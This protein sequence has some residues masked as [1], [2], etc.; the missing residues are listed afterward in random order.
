MTLLRIVQRSIYILEVLLVISVCIVQTAPSILSYAKVTTQR[1]RDFGIRHGIL[2]CQIG[3]LIHPGI[4]KG[5]ITL[6][7]NGEYTT[8]I[9]HVLVTDGHQINDQVLLTVF[10]IDGTPG[11]LSYIVNTTFHFG[12]YI[13]PTLTIKS[14]NAGDRSIVNY[15]ILGNYYSL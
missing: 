10:A 7:A 5:R 6:G 1:G 9:I 3:G 14:T 2:K 13:N 4:A 12:A 15:F 8:G 11:A